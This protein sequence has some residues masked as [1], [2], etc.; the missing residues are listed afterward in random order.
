M[1]RLFILF[2]C[3]NFTLASIQRCAGE[4]R[5]FNDREST[6][7]ERMPLMTWPNYLRIYQID[8]HFDAHNFRV[9]VLNQLVIYL[10]DPTVPG[11]VLHT[12]WRLDKAKDAGTGDFWQTPIPNGR[13]VV[14]WKQYTVDGHYKGFEIYLDVAGGGGSILVGSTAGVDAV[15]F[16]IVFPGPI[17]GIEYK[18][19]DTIIFGRQIEGL[20]FIYDTCYCDFTYIQTTTAVTMGQ[21]NFIDFTI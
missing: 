21:E 19:G 3:Y 8:A 5:Y 13:T 17:I 10:H 9:D 14:G 18:Y 1:L 7:R 12:T 4:S 2:L 16:D 20:K 11:E 6:G 15:E